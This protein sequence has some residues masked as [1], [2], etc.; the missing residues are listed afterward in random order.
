MDEARTGL[1]RGLRRL[2][3]PVC[4]D[5]QRLGL[6][7]LGVVHGCPRGGVDDGVRAPPGDEPRHSARLAEIGVSAPGGAHL[8]KALRRMRLQ[9]AG[10][11][12]RPAEDEQALI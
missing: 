7:R 6:A 4:V 8:A 12:A 5:G 3:S 9:G 2:S 10:Q 1:E 11:L